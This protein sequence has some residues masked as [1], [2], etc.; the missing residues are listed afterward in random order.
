MQGACRALASAAEAAPL[1]AYAA[2]H[3]QYF[4]KTGTLGLPTDG[5]AYSNLT[6]FIS[7]LVRGTLQLVR[8]EAWGDTPYGRDGCA[9]APVVA[10]ATLAADAFLARVLPLSD[11]KSEV[12]RLLRSGGVPRLPLD[13]RRAK[14][15]SLLCADWPGDRDADHRPLITQVVR[16][17][18]HGTPAELA[19]YRAL[20]ADA[21]ARA[22]PEHVAATADRAA[23]AGAAAGRAVQQGRPSARG[24]AALRIVAAAA[25]READSLEAEQD[26]LEASLAAGKK[27]LAVLKRLVPAAKDAARSAADAH[28]AAMAAAQPVRDETLAAVAHTAL[29]GGGS[30]GLFASIGSEFQARE[31]EE[32][33]AEEGAGG[34]RPAKMQRR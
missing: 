16:V 27:R 29:A 18:D 19:T 17:A 24:E 30:A 8:P 20:L 2:D 31:E 13:E 21:A 22:A 25:G 12:E 3:P 15:F 1:E 11:L 34:A 10:F 6:G 32:E 26:A 4:S 33:E 9:V 14:A 5:P 23:A 28:E 7:R